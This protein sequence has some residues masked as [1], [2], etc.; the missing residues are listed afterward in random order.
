MDTITFMTSNTLDS[1]KHI[2]HKIAIAKLAKHVTAHEPIGML[3][4]ANYYSQTPPQISDKT[5]TFC[6]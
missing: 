6:I 2:I 4:L 1:N 3:H 5:D